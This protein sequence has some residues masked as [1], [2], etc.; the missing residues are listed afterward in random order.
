MRHSRLRRG[1]LISVVAAAFAILPVFSRTCSGQQGGSQTPRPPAQ[2]EREEW[3]PPPRQ[4]NVQG[5]VVFEDGTPGPPNV[6]IERFC[7]SG[8]AIP[9]T[10]TGPDGWFSFEIGSG[11]M[12]GFTPDA[13]TGFGTGGA[14]GR[15]GEE[16]SPM[17]GFMTRSFPDLLNETSIT[18]C[19]LRAV[20]PGFRSTAVPLADR[21][22]FDNPD[23]GAIVLHPIAD[24]EGLVYSIVSLR[25]P[26]EARKSF[27]KGSKDLEKRKWKT[28]REHFEKA[29]TVFPQYADAWFA[30]GHVHEQEQ[31]PA[32]AREAFEK[33]TA[34]DPRFVAPLIAL[35]RLDA[36][37]EEWEH[38]AETTDRILTLNPNDFADAYF[39]SAVANFN[40][41]R[42][43]AAERSAR[44][45][46]ARGAEAR[47]PQVV[48]LLALSLGHQDNLEEATVHLKRYLEIAPD[49]DA[50]PL[51]RKQLEGIESYLAQQHAS[52]GK[53]APEP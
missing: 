18:G 7:G 6:L 17:S 11:R 19:M 21:G 49:S 27:M 38:V 10:H 34:A 3:K 14:P 28:A 37:E 32:E 29:V 5:Q 4:V 36:G 35:A 8:N 39:Y 15:S 31:K 30:L 48:H 45:A 43:P 16:A 20:L 47:F 42:H 12:T 26:T 41:G 50:A 44:E 9:E 24:V 33:A 1:V 13:T 23:V 25:A 2:T 51:V 40:L 46:I 53:P 22:R 52:T